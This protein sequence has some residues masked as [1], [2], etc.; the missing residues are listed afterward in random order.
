MHGAGGGH[1]PGRDHPSW[2]HGM[3]AL[4]WIEMRREINELARETRE[5]ERFLTGG[6]EIG[7]D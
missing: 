7:D 5:I 2:W 4:E 6:I 1:A 3:R